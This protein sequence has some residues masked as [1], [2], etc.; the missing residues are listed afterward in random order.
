MHVIIIGV[1]QLHLTSL[2]L[3]YCKNKFIF[4]Y[5][6]II[7]SWI[8]SFV[9]NILYSLSIIYHLK[10]IGNS[11]IEESVD[12]INNTEIENQESNQ[13]QNLK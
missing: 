9:F 3:L 13:E 10:V 2:L 11:L 7:F 5:E 12:N 6:F 1:N 8:N 4:S